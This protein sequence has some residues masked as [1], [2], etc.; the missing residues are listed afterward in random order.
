MPTNV[1]NF[2]TII[3]ALLDDGT[4]SPPTATNGQLT[5]V[6]DAY[7]TQ[8]TS[9]Q[10]LALFPGATLLPNGEVDKAALT[11]SQRAKIALWR[12][13]YEIRQVV[14]QV[15]RDTDQATADGIL[16]AGQAAADAVI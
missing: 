16:A 14:K 10:V 15:Q 11:Q 6:G 1:Q 3:N 4:G 7:V 2:S 8:A 13:R 9:A 12:W 5:A